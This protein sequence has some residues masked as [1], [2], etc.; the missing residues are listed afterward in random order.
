V[1][2]LSGPDGKFTLTNVPVGANIPLVIQIGRWRRQVVIPQVTACG[3][4]ALPAELT[5]LPRNRMEG[6]IPQMAIATGQYDP[7][8]CLLR[9][10]GI[11]DAEF[12][13]PTGPG[14]VHMFA[15]DGARL[16]A[17][18][19]RGDTLVGDAATLAKYDIVLLPC[20]SLDV[21]T[22]R[23]LGN[24]NAYTGKGGRLFLT[25]WSY[26]WL[27][28]M[29]AFEQA[30]TWLR[31]E[32]A[33]GDDFTTVVDQG[34]PKGKAFAEWLGIVGAS[35]VPGQLPIHDPYGGASYFER[36]VA[37]TQGWLYTEQPEKTLQHF[38]FNTPIGAEASKQCGRVV[39]STFH[40]AAE[41]GAG[42]FPRACNND[43][44]TP[45]EKALEFMLFDATACIMPDTDRP[46]VFE[47]P[48]PAPPPPPRMVE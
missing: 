12:T 19:P 44:M 29:G 22:A 14:R 31:E 2:A 46:S 33:V 48:P 39:Y 41:G 16:G 45:Q 8:E 15:Y 32:E 35:T 27:Q 17:N 34:F 42:L 36:P 7:M 1:T 21:R 11:D 3:E 4:T 24:L 18:P 6:D 9:K 25:D 40:V 30:A 5:R 28:D 10:I 38:T 37:P 20:D 43:P 26:T 13:L 23:L 47:P